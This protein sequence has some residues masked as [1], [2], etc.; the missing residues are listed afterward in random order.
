MSALWQ[1]AARLGNE[2]GFCP[3]CYRL[4]QK[5][6]CSVVEQKNDMPDF[7]QDLFGKRER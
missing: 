2:L 3:A 7:M 1:G 6:E 4:C 5:G